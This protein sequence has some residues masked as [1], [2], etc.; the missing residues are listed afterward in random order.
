M[1]LG[2]GFEAS[3]VRPSDRLYVLPLGLD[4]RLFTDSQGCSRWIGWSEIR[5][6]H[7]W[8]M[9]E[10]DHVGKRGVGRA[11]QMGKGHKDPS[12]PRETLIRT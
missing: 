5:K 3:K 8:K 12:V 4:M 11:L 10:K 6:G 2:V 7:G 1:S 9:G